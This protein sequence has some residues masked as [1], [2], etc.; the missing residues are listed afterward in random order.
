MKRKPPSDSPFEAQ[1]K[2]AQRSALNAL[3]RARRSAEKAGVSLSEWEGEFL[4]SV[5]ERVKTHGRAFAD[6]EK[7]APGQALSAMQGRKLKEIA[8]K[9]K[10]E[11]PK[12]W[13]RSKTSGS[14][15]PQDYGN[16]TGED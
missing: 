10:G 13:G 15:R 12:R 14:N 8:A 16:T 7:G 9:A 2:A 4:D 3:K 5:S 6:P 11:E 1:R